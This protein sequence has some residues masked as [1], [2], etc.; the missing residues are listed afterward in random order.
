MSILPP[1]HAWRM[2]ICRVLA[3]GVSCMLL[4]TLLGCTCLPVDGFA[5]NTRQ[6]SRRPHT[7]RNGTNVSTRHPRP[8]PRRNGTRITRRPK[9]KP[10]KTPA[11]TL[12]I[13]ASTAVPTVPVTATPTLSPGVCASNPCANGGTCYT[14]LDILCQVQTSFCLDRG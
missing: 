11:P 6:P 5:V 1:T 3:T 13:S 14:G 12:M 9:K 10:F 8:R 4:L 7:Q 2:L